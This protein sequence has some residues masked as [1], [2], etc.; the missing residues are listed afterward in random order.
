MTRTACIEGLTQVV[1][2]LVMGGMAAAAS[3]THI[4]DLPVGRALRRL[5]ARPAAWSTSLRRLFGRDGI[6]L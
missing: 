4:H 5:Q 1:I 3:F 6:Q 2:L